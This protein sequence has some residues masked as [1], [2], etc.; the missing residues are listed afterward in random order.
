MSDG[1][2]PTDPLRAR[3]IV[4]SEAV[5]PDGIRPEEVRTSLE[6]ILASQTFSQSRRLKRFLQFVV[7]KALDGR[8]DELKEYLIGLEVFDRKRSYDVG[9]D[10]IVRVEAGRLREKLA[11]YYETEGRSDP[12]RIEVPKGRYGAAFRLAPEG[13]A[14]PEQ[15]AVARSSVS[16]FRGPRAFGLAL[17]GVVAL[18]AAAIYWAALLVSSTKSGEPAASG[19]INSIAVLPFADLSPESDQAYFSAG[20]AEELVNALTRVQGLRVAPRSSTLH[21]SGR[22]LDMRQI[23]EA[24]RVNALLEGSV[25]KAANRFRIAVR[26][27]DV[28]GGYTLWAETYERPLEN[29]FAVQEEISQAIVRS[30]RAFPA[31]PSQPITRPRTANI[32]AFNL[33]LK[34][35]YHLSRRGEERIRKAIDYFGQAIREDPQY[36]AAY[37][38]LADSYYSLAFRGSQAPANVL[39]KTKEA[40]LKALEI[41]PALAEAHSSLGLVQM[42]YDWNFSLAERSFLRALEINPQYATAYQ[43]YSLLLMLS[44]Q[45]DKALVYIGRAEDLEPLSPDVKRAQGDIYYRKG[46]YDQAIEKCREAV[47]LDSVLDSAFMCLGRCYEMKGMYQEAIAAFHKAR[48]GSTRHALITAMIMRTLALAGKNDEA[49]KLLNEFQKPSA[50]SYVPAYYMALA[51]AGFG[52]K[53]ST[54]A[55]LDKAFGERSVWIVGLSGDP[56]FD[57]L[58]KDARFTALIHKFPALAALR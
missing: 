33:Y 49:R 9:T 26:V 10:P 17:M 58:R 35:R 50:G 54:M 31:S 42:F 7:E 38:G 27:S 48:A 55:W 57:L 28:S 18:T 52:D 14:L 53:D 19:I 4:S 56:R 2:G 29:V 41:D 1:L 47:D 37:S 36:A 22:N 51:H 13:L 43:R 24:L 45:L 20:L 39:L 40:A 8:T 44:G 5:L 3:Q 25:R 16:F 23:G 15:P 34:G 12:I 46:D 32:E 11:T 6:S 30:L 21:L